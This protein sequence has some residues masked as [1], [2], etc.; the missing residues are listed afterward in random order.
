MSRNKQSGRNA[1]YW[2]R[3][4]NYGRKR[5]FLGTREVYVVWRDRMDVLSECTIVRTVGGDS[6]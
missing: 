1:V 6:D 3:L 5:R 2:R 4:L